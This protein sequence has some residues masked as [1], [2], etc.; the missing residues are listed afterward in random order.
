[1]H[2]I[3]VKCPRCGNDQIENELTDDGWKCGGCG[4]DFL[5]A[6]AHE[7]GRHGYLHG[8]HDTVAQIGGQD[9]ETECPIDPESADGQAWG[10]GWCEG[11]DDACFEYEERDTEDD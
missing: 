10:E 5:P 3:R 6:D 1:M 9:A 11:N 4:Q 2:V 8:Y 7:Y